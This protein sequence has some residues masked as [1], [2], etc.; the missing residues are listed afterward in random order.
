MLKNKKLD[1][2]HRFLK[3][4]FEE[5]G[6]SKYLLVCHTYCA[7]GG[8]IEDVTEMRIGF[9]GKIETFLPFHRGYFHQYPSRKYQK[10]AN[11]L[12]STA[13]FWSEVD[14]PVLRA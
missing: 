9:E 3:P 5:D 12:F 7:D 11:A 6:I 2:T 14:H 13:L 1:K 8:E 4:A 10:S